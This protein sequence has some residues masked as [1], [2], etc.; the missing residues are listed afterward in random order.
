M[1]AALRWAICGL[2]GLIL[3]AATLMRMFYES[4]PT[5]WNMAKYL[6]GYN[7]LFYTIGYL[8]IIRPWRKAALEVDKDDH[9]VTSKK[10]DDRIKIDLD[11]S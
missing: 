2:I 3:V 7:V 11:L 4:L 8:F 5:K 6:F 10:A 1:R 9:E